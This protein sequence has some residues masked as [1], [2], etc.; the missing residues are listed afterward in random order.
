[1]VLVS[2]LMLQQ[3]QASRVAER[4]P[5]F[6]ARFPTVERLARASEESVLAAWSGLGYYRRARFL[7]AA[8]K[9]IVDE[10]GGAFPMTVEGLRS[11]PG[12]GRY[13]AGS[14]SALAFGCREAAVDGNA[15]RVLM[16][17][18]A[19]D[20]QL[21]NLKDMTWAWSRAEALVEGVAPV[22]MGAALLNEGLM[23]LGASVC[24]P[25]APKCDRCPLADL[26]AAH[27]VG[28]EQEIPR[29]KRAA[30]RRVVYVGSVVFVDNRGR[31]LVE[32]RP[33]EGLW[34]GLWQ[35]PSIEREDRAPTGPEIGA[36]LALSGSAERVEA[37]T[38]QTTHREVRFEVWRAGEGE[39]PRR[40]GASWKDRAA[41]EAL[42][43]STP[44]RRILLGASPAPAG[45]RL[46]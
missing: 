40:P 28:R 6:L 3:T 7:H 25:R 24:T 16:R 36:E 19:H 17:L 31:L 1:M 34:G 4:M 26:C 32:R 45:D 41:I 2:E 35:A 43:L 27:C 29:A 9:A 22:R 18:H 38:F 5:E 21:N 42:A 37:F 39:R 15:A 14:I 46:V 33:S 20:G 8:A 13:T 10:H 30:A 11:L 44:Q 12:V 23:E